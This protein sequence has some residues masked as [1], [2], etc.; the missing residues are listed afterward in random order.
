MISFS[1]YSIWK[2]EIMKGIFYVSLSQPED[3]LIGISKMVAYKRQFH[4]DLLLNIIYGI[5]YVLK[6]S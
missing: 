4:V 1:W 6:C 3:C 2:L 5:S